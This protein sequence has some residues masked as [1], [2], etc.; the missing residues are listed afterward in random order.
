MADTTVTITGEIEVMAALDALPGF[1]K[2]KAMPEFKSAANGTLVDAQDRCPYGENH[3]GP[4]PH[5]RDTGRVKEIEDGYSVTFGDDSDAIGY[6][7]FVEV[8][9]R[10]RSGS[11]V[12][13]QPYLLPSF[14]QNAEELPVL[15]EEIV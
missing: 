5:L 11:M 12:A 7:W 4:G 10:T 3:R 13:P 14:E 6:S 1:I 9:H 2:D 8:G 15:L